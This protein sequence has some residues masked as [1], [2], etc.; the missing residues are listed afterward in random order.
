MYNNQ[1]LNFLLEARPAPR[2]STESNNVFSCGWGGLLVISSVFSGFVQSPNYPDKYSDNYDCRWHISVNES[3]F[4]RISVLD[5][6]LG[7]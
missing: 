7:R 1:I 6:S 2:S 5:L 4:I 3:D